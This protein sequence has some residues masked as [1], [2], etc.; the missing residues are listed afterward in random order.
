MRPDSAAGHKELFIRRAV[1][2]ALLEDIDAEDEHL[3][4][5]RTEDNPHEPEER[6]ADEYAEDRHE[7]VRVGQLLLHHETHDLEAVVVTADGRNSSMNVN[8]A[9]AVTSI[10]SEQ[11]ELMPSV[12][13]SMNDIMKLTPQASTTT[14]GLAIGGGNYRT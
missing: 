13:R 5:Q 12:S 4:Q 1:E 9:G 14:S 2:V 7:R 10:S 3:K 8:R 11:I 6:E